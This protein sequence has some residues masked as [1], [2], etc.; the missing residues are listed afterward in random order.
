[1]R[2]NQRQIPDPAVISQD[3]ETLRFYT[4]LVRDRTVLVNFMSILDHAANPVS[5]NLA[6]VAKALGPRL[7]ADVRMLSI[8]VDPANDTPA[9]LQRFAHK[10]G[11]APG[12]R[13]LTSS[14][15]SLDSLRAAFFRHGLEA[16]EPE[17]NA[18]RVAITQFWA[19]FRDD[20]RNLFCENPSSLQDCSAGLIRYGNEALGL[21]GSVPARA[22]P[23]LIL[24]RLDWLRPKEPRNVAAPVRRGGPWPA[25]VLG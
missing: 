15:P 7:D 11:A 16:D 5:R 20:P 10:L 17:D 12:W 9:A 14:K 8:T 21:W 13:F 4:D 2:V 25:P 3:G 23:E 19:A 1:M 18:R 22:R 6:A 24:S